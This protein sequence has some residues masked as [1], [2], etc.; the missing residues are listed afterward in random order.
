MHMHR[1]SE[2]LSDTQGENVVRFCLAVEGRSLGVLGGGFS[3]LGGRVLST[4][5]THQIKHL[6][7]ARQNL[8][9]ADHGIM[10]QMISVCAVLMSCRLINISA[11]AA[12]C[13]AHAQT[14]RGIIPRKA[15]FTRTP[16]RTKAQCRKGT[17]CVFTELLLVNPLP[18]LK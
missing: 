1:P 2:A 10:H 6:V 5:S 8:H 9:F 7:T 13:T 15:A 17:S 4:P 11:G 3:V 14:V 12:L 16:V 18:L